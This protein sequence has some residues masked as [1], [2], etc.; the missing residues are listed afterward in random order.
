[1]SYYPVF[2]KIEGA[3][4]VV[5]GGGAVGLRK[6]RGVVEAGARVTVVSPVFHPDFDDLAVAR[7]EREYRPD[8][9]QGALLVF[10]ATDQREVN[11]QVAEHAGTLGIP[12]NVADAPDECR[13][14]VPARANVEGVQIAVSTGGV[15]PG[16]AARV[17]RRIEQLLGGDHF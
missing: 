1:M 17:R 4:V 15:D 8:D 11:R 16:T 3:R 12:V 10:A 6:A 7:I 5:V 9:L 2:L 13:F 14:I